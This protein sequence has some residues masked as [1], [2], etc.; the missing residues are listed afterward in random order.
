V[1]VAGAL[2]AGTRE[3][4]SVNVVLVIVKLLALLVFIALAGSVFYAG[5][6]EPFMPYGFAAHEEGGHSHGVMAAAAI[7]FFAF[8]GFDAVSTAAEEAKNPSRD[9][10]IGIIGSMIL[11]TL[12]YMAVAAAAL[13]AMLYTQFAGD[14]E[15]LALILRTL[16]HPQ[17][18]RLIGAAA[19]LALPTVIL[20]FMYGQ[21]RIFF[22]MA[23]DGLLPQQLGHVN[24]RTGSPV[25]MTVFTAIVVSV[26]AGVFPL[27]RIVAV[28]NAGTL[29]AFIAVCACMLTLRVREPHRPRIF[30]TPWAW[31]VGIFGIAGCIYLFFSLPSETR[32]Y[33]FIW[34]GIGIVVYLLYAR[35]SSRLAQQ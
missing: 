7:I 20:A 12:L 27:S 17:A 16:G 31:P 34:N 33:F 26:I 6:F 21:S 28:A 9:L 24:P 19:I 8:Y 15:P 14:K 25:A 22:V 32:T 3:S 11:C 13:G 5:N 30:R 23:R 10:K 18:A 2:V 4:A 35:R 1:V 29:C